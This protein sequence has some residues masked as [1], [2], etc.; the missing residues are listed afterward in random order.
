MQKVSDRMLLD[1]RVITLTSQGYNVRGDGVTDDTVAI[2]AAFQAAAAM[3]LKLY[4]P[5]YDY[6]LTNTLSW[7]ITS[8]FEV[9]CHPGATFIADSSFPVD[10][11]MVQPSSSTGTNRFKWV[12]G[13]LDGRNM[14]A[15]VSGAPDLLYISSQNLKYVEIEGVKFL[16]NN[17]RTGTAGDS[18]LFLA[19][20]EDYKVTKCYFQGAVDSGIYISGDNAETVGRRCLVTDCTFKDL[21]VGVISK[22]G[23]QD[24]TVNDNEFERVNTAVVIGGIGD[25][26]TTGRKATIN[27]NIL[28]NVSRGIEARVADGTVIMGNRIEDWGISAAGAAVAEYA[29]RIA[30]SKYCDVVGN[31][32]IQTGLVTPNAATAGILFERR[33][34]LGVDYDSTDNLA[35]GNMIRGASRGVVETTGADRNVIRGNPMSGLTGA[36]MV[37]VGASTLYED[38]DVGNTRSHQRFGASGATP[39]NGSITVVEN[40]GDLIESK[41]TP[42]TNAYILMVGDPASN[43]V[44][45]IAYDHTTDRWTFRAGGGGVSFSIGNGTT[46]F[47]ATTPIA[48]PT[49][50]GSRGGNAALASVLTQLAALGLL[51]DSSSA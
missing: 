46:G 7:T 18:S 13:T 23:F 39:I 33:T 8:D 26:G 29:I 2:K 45:R 34:E 6:K 15:R 31:V 17:D 25:V 37:I 36:R 1:Q 48:K 44:G 19:E 10:A 9:E 16:N 12:G 43:S 27:D 49:V 51:T 20:G 14:P 38:I 22:R 30:G 3:G 5:G 47:Y 21:G 35:L 40:D 28:K 24:H 32:C 50:T 41:L 4:V 11:K 42:G